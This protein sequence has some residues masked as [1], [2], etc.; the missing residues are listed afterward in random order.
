MKRQ[1]EKSK[2]CGTSSTSAPKH[3][4]SSSSQINTSIGESTTPIPLHEGTSAATPE[5]QR[6]QGSQATELEDDGSVESV[7][8]AL[9]RKERSDIWNHF[10]RDVVDGRVKANCNY[11]GKIYYA[12]PRKNEMLKMPCGAAVGSSRSGMLPPKSKTSSIRA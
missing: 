11:C 10:G 6:T 7:L 8:E 12:D 4:S 2:S 1:M 9:K 3:K 5:V